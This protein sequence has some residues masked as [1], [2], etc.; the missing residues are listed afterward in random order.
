MGRRLLPE[1]AGLGALA[2][3]PRFA[4]FG[5][6]RANAAELLAVLEPCLRHRTTAE[7]TAALHAAG[8]PCGEVRGV[9]EALADPHTTA[10]GLVVETEH[11]RFGTVRQVGSPVRAGPPR[12][13]H[14]RAPLLN[15][16]A[17][18]V[19]GE[20]LGYEEARRALLA[21]GGAFG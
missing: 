9:P 2:D 7:W 5:A 19:L 11:P 4:D 12:R 15:E 6:R 20:L 13:D 1:V 10:R 18:Y 14:R 17:D 16:D 8:V 21:A 3:D